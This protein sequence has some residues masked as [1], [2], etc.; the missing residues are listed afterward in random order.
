LAGNVTK[1]PV[2]VL[3]YIDVG[4]LS[5]PNTEAGVHDDDDGSRNRGHDGRG[6]HHF[7]QR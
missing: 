7:Q 4:L 3:Q 1:Y 5:F 2:T 6:G